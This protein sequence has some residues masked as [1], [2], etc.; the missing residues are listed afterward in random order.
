VI[1]LLV[2]SLAFLR[3]SE[4]SHGKLEAESKDVTNGH[5]IDGT[6]YC[7]DC[8]AEYEVEKGTPNLLPKR[9]RNALEA[10]KAMKRIRRALTRKETKSKLTDDDKNLVKQIMASNNMAPNYRRFVADSML[11]APQSAYLY[12]RYEDLYLRDLLEEQIRDMDKDIVFA[13]VGSGPGRYLVQLGARMSQHK[14]V[15]SRYREHTET[16]PL[17]EFNALYKERLK[18]VI[19]IDYA[20]EMIHSGLEWLE[21]TRLDDL[22]DS[23][24]IFQIIA[25]AQYLTMDFGGTPY[26]NTHKIVTCMFQTMGNQMSHNLQV[27]LLKKMKEFAQPSGVVVLSVF[28]EGVFDKYVDPYYRVIKRSIGKL[29]EVNKEAKSIMTTY[30]VYSKWLSKKGV[31]ELF[32]EAEYDMKKVQILAGIGDPKDGGM[33]RYP[34]DCVYLAD[35]AQNVARERGIIAKAEV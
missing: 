11:D 24:V 17:Y 5:I 33:P 35:Y 6:L 34:K 22:V 9:I 2:D 27:H 25:A 8:G 26:E 12:E 20:E 31:N 3:C 21:S 19:G 16:G 1:L 32:S 13:E 14:R 29:K 15:A 10:E 7:V 18:K 23:D 30:G 28:N 4:C